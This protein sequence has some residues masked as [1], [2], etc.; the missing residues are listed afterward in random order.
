VLLLDIV[1]GWAGLG[2]CFFWSWRSYCLD[3]IVVDG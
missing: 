3:L 2:M 1:L